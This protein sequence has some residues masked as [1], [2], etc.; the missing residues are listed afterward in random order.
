MRVNGQLAGTQAD[1]DGLISVVARTSLKFDIAPHLGPRR[2]N[3]ADY[4][5]Q[6]LTEK[7]SPGVREGT[8][9]PEARQQKV[10]VG[11]RSILISFEASEHRR[12]SCPQRWS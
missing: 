5:S 6:M 7:Q 9:S 4:A 1:V 12:L 2:Q 3:R 8:A 10:K 11:V